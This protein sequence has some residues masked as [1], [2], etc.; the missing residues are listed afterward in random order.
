MKKLITILSLLLTLYIPN[1]W[2]MCECD[3]WVGSTTEAGL[4][5]LATDEETVTGASD[6]VVC[7]PGNI[8]A[9]MAAPGAIGGTTPEAGAFT[10]L[11]VTQNFQPTK[12]SDVASAGAMT[13]GNGNLFD[14]TGTTTINTIVSKGIGTIVV[15]EFDGAL[16]L[17][18]SADLFLP[19]A[20]N[21]TTAAG[22]IA[23]L[24]EY[25]SGDWRC[26]NYMRADGTVLSGVA[27]ITS[28]SITGITDLAIADGGT[29]AGTAAD[30]F[31]A[32]KQNAT[33]AATGVVELATNAE[34]AAFTDE[35][36]AVTPEGLGYA[37]AGLLAYGV[38]WDEDL[39]SPTLTRTGALA[40]LAA[41]ASPGN[42]ALP[43]HAA[44]RRCILSDAGVVQYYLGATDSTKKEDGVTASV[45]DGTDGQVMVEIPKFAYKYSYDATTNVHS[46]SI[47]SV[48]LPGYEWH[49]AF[50]KDGAWVDHRYI[51]AYEGIGYDNGTTAYIDC[52][53]AAANNW[54]G[55]AIDLA[56]D[57][58]GSVSGFAPMMDETRAEFRAVALNRGVGYRQQD[59]YLTSAVQLLNLVEYASFY[60]QDVIGMGR[61]ELTGGNW[62]KDSYIGVTGKSNG[63]GNATAN[64]GGNTNDAYMSYRGIEN[65]YGN[66]YK[67]V[68]G[69]NIGMAATHDGGAD[70]AVFTDSG[71]SWPVDAFIGMTIVNTSDSDA[72]GTITDN[73]GTT[74]TVA[75]GMT[76]GDN[77]FDDGDIINISNIPWVSNT[78]TDFA[79]DTYA[80]YTLLKDTG[81]S[82]I[83]LHNA[84]GYQTTLEQ[85]KG[86][87][88]PSA[89]GG[90]SNEYITDYYYQSSGWRVV[91]FGGTAH[92]GS[93]AGAFYVYA[94]ST[95][96]DGSANLG[97]RLAF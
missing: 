29:G 7:T 22:D 12:G 32:L 67:W 85:T 95:S 80:S 42:A 11:A 60:S 56:N 8:T 92:S 26:F 89:V 64:I 36:R 5:E 37:M 93:S 59:F 43:I 19:T 13:L 51:G 77:D 53:T 25:A 6:A 68:D 75:G 20:G 74:I 45:L 39:S 84:N 38:Q 66:I 71:E 96:S 52:G 28:G 94:I 79:D 50:Y 3:M 1:L 54:A 41:A 40:G 65:F 47:S 57:K 82:G 97:G 34:T 31:T 88:L 86:G 44:M 70:Q 18:H 73:D 14:I 58:L 2:A 63:N 69:I 78:E 23:A 48:L 17:T 33:G 16:Q 76:G 10:T 61:T 87:F 15:L 49:P 27:A 72:T 55:G 46:W 90:S 62:V 24:Y 30:A 35:S 21:I 83:T 81:G 4:V 91:K 9:K